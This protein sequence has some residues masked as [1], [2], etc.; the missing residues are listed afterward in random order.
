[1]IGQ[2]HIKITLQNQIANGEVGHAYLFC[3]P[4]GLGKTTAARILAKAINCEKRQEGQSEPCND[5]SSCLDIVNN[6]SI[7][8]IEI[9]AASHTGVDNVRENIIE[10]SRFTPSKSKFKVFIIDEVHMLSTAAFNAL[11][12]TLEEPPAHVIFVLCTTEIYK[13]PQTIISRCQRFD[14]KK[15]LTQELLDLLKKVTK[16]ENKK[17]E[18]EVLRNIVLHS[19]GCVR[20][21]QSLLGKVLSLGDDIKMEQAEII[22]PKAD[23]G[24]TIEFINYL[25]QKNSTAA[26]EL[27]NRLVEGGVDLQVFAENLIEML[28]K[29]ML[30]KVNSNL[31]DYGIELDEETY[32]SAEIISERISVESLISALELFARVIIDLKSTTIYQLP[33]EMAAIKLTQDVIC[34][35]N[36]NFS[37]GESIE[38]IKERV[39]KKIEDTQ[40]VD[41]EVRPVQIVENTILSEEIIVKEDAEEVGVKFESSSSADLNKIKENWSKVV[42]CLLEKNFT[43]SSLL[44]ISQPLRCNN[45]VL[46]IVVKSGFY[47]DRLECNANKKV[48]EDMISQCVMANV[49]IRGV[50]DSNLVIPDSRESENK[51]VFGSDPSLYK[52]KDEVAQRPSISTDIVADVIGMF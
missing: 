2:N 7:D 27:I 4:R 35:S 3:G 45:N 1:M 25:V 34:A 43:L 9:D 20:D 6:R 42:E 38:K 24:I 21:A 44:R 18:E 8:I 46:E 51:P 16:E 5:C 17:V 10:N 41:K 36:D 22:L 15:V 11:L 31:S 50:V 32:K 49:S 52:P 40:P 47:K 30:L 23:Y 33:L 37:K 19:E 26:V 28:R 14:F 12:K 39:N 13:L 29:I 48:I